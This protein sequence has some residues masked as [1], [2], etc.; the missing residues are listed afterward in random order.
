[1]DGGLPLVVFHFEISDQ[2]PVSM[3]KR[4][5][6]RPGTTRAFASAT[7]SDTVSHVFHV[8]LSVYVFFSPAFFAAQRFF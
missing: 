7:A 3:F 5:I 6:R 8:P 4:K 1:M 2:S